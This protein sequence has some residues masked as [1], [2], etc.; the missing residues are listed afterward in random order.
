[1]IR[2]RGVDLDLIALTNLKN[3]LLDNLRILR[4]KINDTDSQLSHTKIT[5]EASVESGKHLINA[6]KIGK[7]SISHDNKVLA[8]H[9]SLKECTTFYPTKKQLKAV[10][11]ALLSRSQLIQIFNHRYGISKFK[12][13]YIS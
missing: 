3:E 4:N 6:L 1:M 8:C 10:Y 7:V 5:T 11:K 2:Q 12:I 13:E 9:P